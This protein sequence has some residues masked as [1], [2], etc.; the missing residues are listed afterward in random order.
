MNR[1]ESFLKKVLK[2]HLNDSV[3]IVCHAAIGE[4]IV[5]AITSTPIESLNGIEDFKNTAVYEF[6]ISEDGNHKMHVQNCTKHL[7]K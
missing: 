5:A 2:D 7:D 4:A 1:A 3:L 6:E